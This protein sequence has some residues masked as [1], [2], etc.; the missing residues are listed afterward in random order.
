MTLK[1]YYY[2]TRLT[3]SAKSE[4]VICTSSNVDIMS[5]TRAILNEL[6]T[7]SIGNSRQNSPVM[8]TGFKPFAARP[9]VPTDFENQASY[10][11][12]RYDG[13]TTHICRQA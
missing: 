1:A 8:S 13:S 11:A 2:C 7:L 3:Y 9:I 5:N 6:N 4:N 10:R 12:C